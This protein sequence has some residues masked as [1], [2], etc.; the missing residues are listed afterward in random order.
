MFARAVIA[1]CFTTLFILTVVCPTQLRAQTVAGTIVGTVTDETGAVLPGVT[2]TATGVATNVSRTVLTTDTGQYVIPFL[3]PGEYAVSGELIGF[4]KRVISPLRLEVA[5]RARVDLGLQVGEISEVVQVVGQSSMVNSED[6]TIGQVIENKRVVDL[7]LNGRQW[8]ELAFL[9][10]GVHKGAPGHYNNILQGIS[11]TGTGGRPTNNNFQLDGVDNVSVNCGYF[12]VAPSLDTVQEFK[13]QTSNYSAEFGRT[14]GT[15]INVATKRGTNEFHGTL[16]EFIRNDVFDARNFFNRTDR[17]GDGKADAE[18]LKRNQFGGN[19]GGPILKNR[20]FFFY[21][22]E[23]LIERKARTRVAAVPFGPALQGDF[24]KAG[25]TIYDPLTTRKNPHFDAAKKVTPSNPKFIRDAFPGNNIPANRIHPVA[26]KVLGFYPKPNNPAD[27]FRNFINTVPDR[28]DNL[29]INTRIDH[30]FSERD[31]LFGRLTMSN[32]SALDFGGIPTMFDT[33]L[34]FNGR[35]A[36]VNWIHTFSPVL[37]NESRLGYNRLNFGRLHPRMGQNI[38]ADLGIKGTPGG[39]LSGFPIFWIDGFSTLGDTEPYG[40]IDNIYQ[41]VNMTSYTTGNHNLKFGMDL[42]RIQNDYFIARTP[43]GGY[44]AA[45]YFTGVPDFQLSDGL[46]DFLLGIPY[47]EYL[48]IAGDIGRTRTTNFNAFFQDDWKVSKNLTV[49]LGLRYEL[50]T[51]P[52]DKFHRQ[53]TVDYATGDLLF[54]QKAPLNDPHPG[55][56]ITEKDLPVPFRLLDRDSIMKGDY[57]N[58]GPR[59][60]LAYRI[61]GRQGTVIRAGYGM[62]FGYLP[63]SDLTVNSQRMIPFSIQLTNG[64]DWVFPELNGFDIASGGAKQA[65]RS[66]LVNVAGI[67]PNLEWSEIQQWSLNVQHEFGGNLILDLGYVGNHATHLAERWQM[68]AAP[69]PGPGSLQARRR[70]P[71]RYRSVTVVQGA[72]N[73][74]YNGFLARLEKRFSRGLA[75]QGSYTW[76]KSIG[77]GSETYGTPGQDS[78]MQDPFNRRIEK[79]LAPDDIRQ[80][81]AV[82]YIWELPFGKGRRFMASAHPVLDFLFGGWQING[83]TSFHTGYHT[84][85][86]GGAFTNMGAST[87][88]D[89]IGNPNKGFKFSVD[90]AFNTKAFARPQQFQ[91]GTAPRGS[92]ETPGFQVWDFSLLKNTRVTEDVVIQFRAEAFNLLNHANFGLPNRSFDSRSFGRV[93]SAFDP[94]VL[95]FGFKLL[96]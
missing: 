68:N 12:S 10:P 36:A 17:D 52:V 30:M 58:F 49:N 61:G 14:G 93:S 95:Q 34:T 53:G 65:L 91:F 87:R 80:R 67:D 8:M 88:P 46:A 20:T 4:K 96:F 32:T 15:V 50:F 82:S 18:P 70:F 27:P 92:I 60:G 77:Y 56:G 40:N 81:L 11:L 89:Q 16:F 1:T 28:A 26:A 79:G 86:V 74:S 73:N 5:Q 84:T 2:V 31:H 62:S 45:G 3:P 48:A 41:V 69:T 6:V 94:R 42:R 47:Q 44:W 23:H 76:S 43:S 66:Q 59:I 13:I 71:D 38:A 19:I 72:V 9:T 25:Y 85:A 75:F 37:I 24:T 33:D 7:P 63:F 78:G 35:N 83:I 54:P 51:P 57:N 64:F 29:L 21:N 22:Q 90:Q 39:K 55:A